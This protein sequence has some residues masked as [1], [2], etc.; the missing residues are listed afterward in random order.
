MT[1]TIKEE[2]LKALRAHEHTGR[3]GHENFLALLEQNLGRNLRRQK[4]GPKN[5]QAS[6][7]S[8]LSPEALLRQLMSRK[9]EFRSVMQ[10]DLDRDAPTSSYGT[11]IA[12]SFPGAEPR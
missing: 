8:M 3:L 6:E 11:W 4:P 12:L 1:S 5:V 7:M 2:E 9:S 10:Q